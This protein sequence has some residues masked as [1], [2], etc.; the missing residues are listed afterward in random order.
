LAFTRT[1]L[2]GAGVY[3]FNVAGDLIA[4]TVVDSAAAVTITKTGAG[5]LLLNS[6]TPELTNTNSVININQGAVTAVLSATANPLGNAAINLNGG[7]L[8]L[9]SSGGDVTF[10]RPVQ[11]NQNSTLEAGNFGGG[12]VDGVIASVTN[13]LTVASGRT[14]TVRSRNDYTLRLGA[15]GGGG[16]VIVDGGVVGFTGATNPNALTVNSGL[17]SITTGTLTPVT[18]A[19]VN[20][21]GTLGFNPGANNTTAYSGPLAVNGGTLRAQSGIADLSGATIAFSTTPTTVLNS[22]KGRFL[23][24]GG[25]FVPSLIP[26]NTEAGIASAKG[27][28]AVEATLFGPLSFGPYQA[29]DGAFTAFFGGV[30]AAQRF[31][32]AFF[33]TFTAPATGDFRAQAASVDDFGGFW[34]DRNQNGIFELTG[35]A[36]SELLSSQVCCGDGPIGTVPL[37]SGQKYQVAIGV[38]DTGGGSSLI[39]RIGLP[40][41]GM[42]TINPSDPAQAGLWSYDA[43]GGNVLIDPGAQ[44]R[45]SSING[46]SDVNLAGNGA[47]LMLNSAAAT[48][49][50]VAVLRTGGAA[51]DVSTVNLG[52]NN[53]VVAGR[54]EVVADTTLVKAGAGTLTATQQSLAAGSLLQIEAGTVV[55]AGPDVAGNTGAVQVNGGLLRVTGAISG[56]VTV[57][58]NGTLDGTGRV[59][60]TTVQGQLV[61][62]ITGVGTLNTADL[63]FGGTGRLTIELQDPANYDK[64]NVLGSVTLANPLLN[65]TKLGGAVQNNDLFFIV[66]NDGADGVLGQFGNIPNQGQGNPSLID[67]NGQRYLVSYYGDS[68]NPTGF[69]VPGGNDIVLRAVP[70]PQ[71]WMTLAGGVGALVGLQRFRRRRS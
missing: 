13:A 65:V 25:E 49:S 5:N 48:T 21:A 47:T 15:V 24:G 3:N 28:T 67:L 37:V 62:G 1:T 35:S 40:T 4:G 63:N 41:G 33:G 53:S 16:D 36:G 8:R 70:E 39:G 45:A 60:P 68:S 9:S 52:A 18:G 54:L 57:A 42:F 17:A 27:L 55:L 14:L 32:A 61:P 12:A 69:D 64:I 7:G 31:T 22:L 66:V 34:I 23:G 19:S 38:E 11:I 43:V 20:P 2:P 6:A 59:G 44:L 50:N 30:N 46:A 58:N 10:A 51:T 29:A 56:A 71:T 26:P